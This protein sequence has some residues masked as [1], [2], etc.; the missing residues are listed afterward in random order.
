MPCLMAQSPAGVQIYLVTSF[1]FTLFQSAGLRNDAFRQIFGL[2]PRGAPPPEGKFV[3][4]HILYTQLER[5]TYGIL[6]PKFQYNVRPYGQMVSPEEI[7]RFEE[8]AK[9]L[10][11][12]TAISGLGVLAPENQPAFEPSPTF[13][14]VNSI[15]ESVKVRGEKEKNKGQNRIASEQIIEIAASPEEIMEAA[16][17]GDRPAAPIRIA[18][19]STKEKETTLKTKTLTMKKKRGKSNKRKK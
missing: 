17:R 7:K 14:I 13:L 18:P 19:E 3:K 15:A 1:I 10:V 4:E 11:K 9:E 12:N 5:D 2:E 8:S 6:S 16:N